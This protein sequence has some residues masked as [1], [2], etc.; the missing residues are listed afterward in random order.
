MN[1]AIAFRSDERANEARPLSRWL[2]E[3]W[4][5]VVA[6]QVKASTYDSYRR[7]LELHVLPE[8]GG[9]CLNEITPRM[10]TLF[11]ARL[12]EPTANRKHGLA[13]KTIRN[14]HIV[15]HKLFADAVEGEL[16]SINP[17]NRAKVPRRSGIPERELHFWQPA[18]LALFLRNTRD[19]EL[20]I[21]WHVAS[22]TGMRRGELLGLRWS[23]VDLEGA[24]L[25][26]RRNLIS[27]AY[28]VIETTPKSNRARV[29]D[30]DGETVERLRYLCSARYAADREDQCDRVFL[31]SDGTALHPDL[32]SQ[33]FRKA[34]KEAGVRPI[35]FH[36]LRHTHATIAL[37]AGIPAKVISERLGHATPE[38]TLTQY[39]HVIPGM[40]AE[41][42]AQIA[43][44]V[45]AAS[46]EDL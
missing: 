21:L 25:S 18:E 31:R 38:F 3:E 42:A 39:A 10:L 19:D 33:A 35:R 29:V 12:R 24:R 40:Q 46:F 37:R 43:D 6:T 45:R 30:L 4:L 17:A 15:V 1:E 23:D 27:V 41:A 34:M 13:P 2:L 36:D 5:P 9:Q 26:V 28:R 11:Y 44:L 16:L 8:F 20:G 14:I 32:A 22:M 7:I